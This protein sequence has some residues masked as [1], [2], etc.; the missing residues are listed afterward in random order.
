LSGVA[1][2]TFCHRGGFLVDVGSYEGAI[3]IAEISLQAKEK[4]SIWHLLTK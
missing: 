3:K 2:A 4:K 1:D